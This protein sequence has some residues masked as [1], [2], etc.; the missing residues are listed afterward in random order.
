MANNNSPISLLNIDFSIKK[1]LI[2]NWNFKGELSNTNFYRHL[3]ILDTNDI[4]KVQSFLKLYYKKIKN[5]DIFAIK[6][7]FKNKCSKSL[8]WK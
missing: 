5:G 2:L 7:I 4:A 8:K 3:I 1:G 6:K